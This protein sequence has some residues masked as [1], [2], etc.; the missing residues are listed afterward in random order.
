MLT[1][2]YLLYFVE[3]LNS[4][5][6][7]PALPYKFISALESTVGTYD[8]CCWLEVFAPAT[9]GLDGDAAA[10]LPAVC[11]TSGLVPEDCVVPELAVLDGARLLNVWLMEIS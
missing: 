1:S 9:C 4:W 10:A 6:R 5:M 11:A 2:N 3:S 8:G 7:V